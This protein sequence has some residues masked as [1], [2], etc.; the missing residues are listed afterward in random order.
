MIQDFA[1]FRVGYIAVFLKSVL[2]VFEQWSFLGVVG[3]AEM[4]C[5]LEHKMFEVVG[6]TCCLS[7]VVT[8]A[9]THSNISLDT[10]FLLVYGEVNLHSVVKSVNS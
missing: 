8:A 6:K 2:D 7:R 9:G 4:C 1:L 3:C 10:W 5:T